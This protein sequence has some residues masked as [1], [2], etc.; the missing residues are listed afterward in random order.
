MWET[1]T[2]SRLKHAL[3]T[4][5][6]SLSACFIPLV[7]GQVR[8]PK[9]IA[10]GM[11]LQRDAALNVWGWASAGEKVSVQFLDSIYRTTADNDGSWQVT[12]P[13]VKA[14]GPY[15]MFVRA[16]N[17]IKISDVLIG[18]VWICSG[19]SNM[20]LSMKRVSPIY[21]DD[22]AH[23]SNPF[24]RHFA[25]PQRYDFNTP[26]ED[27]QGGVWKS[28]NPENILA[29]S[30][31]AYFFAKEL[32]DANKV[33]IGLINA[34]LGGSPAEA[35]MCEDALKTFPAHYKELQ[36]FKDTA[37][38]RRIESGDN[39]RIGAWYRLLRQKDEGY[40]DPAHTWLDPALATDAWNDTQI[41]G[42]WAKTSLGPVNGVVWF[43]KNIQIPASMIGQPA[44]LNLGRIVD[45][46]S[47]FLNGTFVGTTSY[48][49]PPRRY[50]IPAGILKEG[51][52]TL[53]VRVISNIGKGGFVPDKPYELKSAGQTIDLK[54]EWQYRLGAVMEPL[55]SQT[56]VR[57]KPAGLYNAMIHPLLQ[58]RIKGAIWYQG[59]SNA[60]KPVEYR[61][62][63]PAMINDWRKHWKQGD[64]P[65][66]FVQLTNF[67]EARDQPC[68]SDWAV[69]RE[70]QQRTLSLPQTAM[71]VTIDIGEWNDIHPLN[72]KDV[73][74]RLALAAQKI[75]YGNEKIVCS[76][77]ELQS[78]EIVGSKVVL[79]FSNSGKKL[80]TKEGENL[81]GFA[82]AGA[83]R[84]FVWAE[85]RIKKNK[86]IVSSP[87]VP[88]PVAV[89]YAWAD[90]PEANLYNKTGLP[91]A[92][93]RTDDWLFV[94]PNPVR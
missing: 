71:A 24:I 5:F 61:A 29:F 47:V 18:D 12:M 36:I 53:V 54:G 30:A 90:N 56:F 20:E 9:L 80:K 58:Y 45:A 73:G 88:N 60:K 87:E 63:F 72:K 81:K 16:T 55:A 67:M 78:M 93:F 70:A 86:V 33:P 11:V 79:T 50:E 82:L 27:L 49:Y 35:W 62:L 91:A 41:P 59:E 37:L 64:F 28:A 32:Y 77:P 22:I 57:W 66:L 17:E 25:V 69:L 15:E 44:L 3:S 31:V 1:C 68:E 85:A 8:L 83:D 34:S 51:L 10:D 21:P 75:A 14:G 19:Q 6:F 92:P 40:K 2:R 23:S 52:N 42:Y 89:R 43:R 39:A 76:G 46:D 26:Q 13:P 74:K 38:I 48:Q 4:L 84:R 7:S 65:F 94:P